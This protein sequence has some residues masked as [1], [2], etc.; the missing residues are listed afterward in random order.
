MTGTAPLMNP[1]EKLAERPKRSRAWGCARWI[2]ITMALT[3]LLCLGGSVLAAVGLPGGGVSRAPGGPLKIGT[4]MMD[5]CAG[6]VTKPRFQVGVGWQAM[7]LSRT[8]P[9]IVWSPRAVCVGVPVWPPFFPYRGE[10]M[11]PP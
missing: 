8:P 5:V 7:V 10:W 3:L 11:L 4:G 2:V 1:S 9:A 6:A